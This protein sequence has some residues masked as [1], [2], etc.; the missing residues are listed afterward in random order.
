M[1]MLA[2]INIIANLVIFNHS[3][4]YGDYAKPLVCVIINVVCVIHAMSLS[5]LEIVLIQPDYYYSA[6]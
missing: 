6:V 3:E 2:W 1:L 5:R 4:Y